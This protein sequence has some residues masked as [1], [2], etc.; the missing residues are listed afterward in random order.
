MITYWAN[1]SRA[2]TGRSILQV[3][4]IKNIPCSD[5]PKFSKDTL[6]TASK[7]FDNLSNKTLSITNQAH[8]DDIRDK[9]NYAVSTMFGLE[10]YETK[11]IVKLWCDEPSVRGKRSG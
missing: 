1:G 9:I 6:D 7:E 4:A 10:N 11:T 3:R 8:K 2:Q 5:F